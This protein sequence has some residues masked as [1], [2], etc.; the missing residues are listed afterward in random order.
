MISTPREKRLC[1][2]R[3]EDLEPDQYKTSLEDYHTG[4]K[5]KVTRYADG[6]SRVHWGGPCGDTCYNE[7]GEEC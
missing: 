5:I 3:L 6:T 4:G 1:Y 7:Y 2:K